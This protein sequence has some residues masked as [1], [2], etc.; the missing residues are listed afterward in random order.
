M[1]VESALA[2]VFASWLGTLEVTSHRATPWHSATFS[3]T[4]HA[5]TV[6]TDEAA[7]NPSFAQEIVEADI[8]IPKGFVADIVV[9]ACPT[10]DACRLS[11]DV[12]TIDA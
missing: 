1:S 11:I 12:L 3:G 5:F 2:A 4:R 8:A 7:D 6:V 10:G 9:S